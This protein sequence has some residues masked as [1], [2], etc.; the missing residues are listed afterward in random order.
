MNYQSLFYKGLSLAIK[1]AT[2]ILW[3]KVV[4]GEE[5]VQRS[6]RLKTSLLPVL[7][8]AA[9]NL[10]QTIEQVGEEVEIDQITTYIV[11]T[12][13]ENILKQV[14]CASILEMQSKSLT[15]I[16]QEFTQLFAL[17]TGI[18]VEKLE[19]TATFVF[20]ALLDGCQKTFDEAIDLGLIAPLS[21]KQ[22]L[23]HRDLKSHL[24]EIERTLALLTL[25]QQPDIEAIF[26]FLAEYRRQLVD[27]HGKLT[28]PFFD[29]E[30]EV[31]IEAIYIAP[32]FQDLA[33]KE[34]QTRHPKHFDTTEISHRAVITG[35]P[36]AGK[37]AYGYKL[38]YDFA[39]DPPFKTINERKV[40]PILV[41]LRD[42]AA[43][44]QQ[45]NCSIL[46]FIET[47]L[48]SKYQLTPPDNAIEYLLLNGHLIVIFDGLDELL[49][50]KAR[51]E[52]RDNIQLFCNRYAST[53]VLVT[54][55]IVGYT[56]AP[57][58]KTKFTAY[59][60]AEFDD[61]QVREYVTKW[62][63]LNKQLDEA[64]RNKRIK[65][66]LEES[67]EL[68]DLRSNPL[69][70]ALMC[71][72]YKTEG[73]IPRSRAELYDK[74][75]NMLLFH[76][77]KSIKQLEL[78]RAIKR[79]ESKIKNLMGYLA[80]WIYGDSDLEKGITEQ[81]L[82]NKAANFLC[83]KHVN[84]ID[85]AKAIAKDF[86]QFCRARAWIFTGAGIDRKYGEELYCFTHRTFLEY[87]V[88]YDY[89]RTHS[90][91]SEFLN[92]IIKLLQ[93]GNNLLVCQIAVQIKNRQQ[94]D[95]EDDI[96]FYLL[97]AIEQ[98]KYSA[99]SLDIFRFTLN[100]LE[101]MVPSYDAIARI[102][103]RVLNL[104][105]KGKLEDSH[106]EPANVRYERASAMVSSALDSLT[107]VHYENH[108]NIYS[109]L[110][111]QLT[112]RIQ[113]LNI[114]EV[115]T[116]LE[117]SSY[118]TY[119]YGTNYSLNQHFQNVFEQQASSSPII[120]FHALYSGVIDLKEFVELHGVESCF[121]EQRNSFSPFQSY[122][123]IV[124]N[125]LE[126]YLNNVPLSE[127]KDVSDTLHELSYLGNYLTQQ[128]FP[129]K[130]NPN[131]IHRSDADF[132]LGNYR[133]GGEEGNQCFAKAVQLYPDAL[134][135]AFIIFAVILDWEIYEETEC[136][137]KIYLQ[138]DNR[139]FQDILNHELPFF[140]YTRHLL[141]SRYVGKDK[142]L[143]EIE[144]ELV[145]C[146]FNTQQRDIVW[147]WINSEIDLFGFASHMEL[148]F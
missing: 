50:P 24:D 33:N 76:L 119:R 15:L 54:S 88:A 56:E 65:K 37:T 145:K 29:A 117:I 47:I 101:F 73:F 140:A 20:Q 97:E 108:D 53:P 134:F 48:E 147:S 30:K 17:H 2:K 139:I 79:I 11:S 6:E 110:K 138:E 4:I 86:F 94:P 45:H 125:L 25:S 19:D 60:L 84:E 120:G 5:I 87:F 99:G 98:K 132:L 18:A 51:R 42:F 146:N 124:F 104:V 144:A 62:F 85:E 115:N 41:V 22:N 49:E 92:E 136:G 3:Q 137:D 70:L 112:A 89:A 12:E 93:R 123:S 91:L 74:C 7:Q 71:N 102:V 31:P 44:K 135:A 114:T 128:S 100:C 72:V 75:T 143:Q 148:L 95:T 58:D 107:K 69:M 16:Q 129:L 40:T 52:V 68:R 67:R 61:I 126:R 14:F 122:E 78:P 9:D 127:L 142:Y 46:R 36:G 23:Y 105:I 32:H 118:L 106:S 35:D 103:E 1:P 133:L 111:K 63:S 116:C 21:A 66:F 113:K 109:C 77:D 80:N 27:L 34:R 96:L 38:I 10:A 55:R 57:L 82:V 81:K 43:Y 28:P 130:F 8:E 39:S 26:K 64:T 141:V 13:V 121:Y 131:A 59:E 83:P 90:S